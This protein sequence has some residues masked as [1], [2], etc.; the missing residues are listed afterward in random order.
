MSEAKESTREIGKKIIKKYI[1]HQKVNPK[2]LG[3]ELLNKYLDTPK[4]AYLSCKLIFKKDIRSLTELEQIVNK[5]HE[6]WTKKNDVLII[7]KINIFTSPAYIV[8]TFTIGFYETVHVKYLQ[9]LRECAKEI[10]ETY[11][12]LLK[13]EKEAEYKRKETELYEVLEKFGQLT[14]KMEDLEDKLVKN[15]S[16]VLDSGELLKSELTKVSKTIKDQ[17]NQVEFGLE[18]N[19][20]NSEPN[21]S[22][23]KIKPN[24]E[25]AT[26]NKKK[27]MKMQARKYK[28]NR[29]EQLLEHFKIKTGVPVGLSKEDTSK[30]NGEDRVVSN[31]EMEILTYFSEEVKLSKKQIVPKQKFLT[32]K[33]KV[34][35]ID[36]LWMLLELEGKEEI[37]IAG[38]LSCRKLIKDLGKFTEDLEKVAIG[39]T[40]F[41]YWVYCSQ[42][43][44]V[45]LEGYAA[46]KEFL[47]NA[48]R[49]KNNTLVN[50]AR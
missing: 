44:L 23:T 35:F 3:V 2:L 15:E 41:N 25:S 45:K 22:A 14:K 32:L 26:N 18:D 27:S 42:E 5:I 36:Y 13:H 6:T 12:N 38:K 7:K 48:L 31:L 8:L 16:I 34:E 1:L 43:M 37:I 47:S 30:K 33:E 40:I 11:D 21:K 28:L 19:Q 20:N 9:E 50:E 46:L 10:I 4:E 29:S 49:L 24:L 17:M 39:P